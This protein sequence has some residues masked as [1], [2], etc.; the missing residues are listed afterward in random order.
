MSQA[1]L[2]RE[3]D[4]RGTPKLPPGSTYLRTERGLHLY[5]VRGSQR[6]FALKPIAG[7]WHVYEYSGG[8]NCGG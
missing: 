1:R 8:C 3:W 7:G 5:N 2:V 6:W 4:S